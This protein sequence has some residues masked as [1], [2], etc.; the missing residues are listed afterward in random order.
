MPHDPRF[1][2]DCPDADVDVDAEP[3]PNM[4]PV[5]NPAVRCMQVLA[6]LAIL[7]LFVGAAVVLFTS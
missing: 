3:I 6:G 2:V 4:N 7:M 1:C 5:T